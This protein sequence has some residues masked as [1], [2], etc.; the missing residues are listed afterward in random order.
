MISVRFD[1]SGIQRAFSDM[2]QQI[3]AAA[4]MALNS[5]ARVVEKE[6]KRTM[7][8][9]FDRPTPFVMDSLRTILSSE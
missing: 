5:T 6:L 3:P 4:S 2:A 9:I 7:Y 8:S 1:S